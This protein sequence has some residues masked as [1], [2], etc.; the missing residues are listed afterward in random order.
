MVSTDTTDG[1]TKTN[2]HILPHVHIDTETSLPIKATGVNAILIQG[3]QEKQLCAGMN[4]HE[5]IGA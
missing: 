3:L 1:Y 5:S 2:D 4:F